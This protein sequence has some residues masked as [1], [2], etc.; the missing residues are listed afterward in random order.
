MACRLVGAKPLSEP[1]LEFCYPNLRNQK[2]SKLRVIGLCEGKA[3]NAEN[4]F[5]WWRLHEPLARYAKLRVAHA[6]GMPGTF[7]PCRRLQRKLLVS[8][9]GMHVTHVP[10]RMPG[11]LTCGGGENDPGIPGACT[12]AILLIRQEARGMFGGSHRSGLTFG[13]IQNNISDGS[14]I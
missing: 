6:P 5:I 14:Q 10:W 1:M 9:P 3:S 13:V 7:F 12:P 4:V 2:T 11:S 8:D